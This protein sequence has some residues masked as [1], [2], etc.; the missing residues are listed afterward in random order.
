MHEICFYVTKK[1]WGVAI[2]EYLT[3]E[4]TNNFL[5][6]KQYGKY[7]LSLRSFD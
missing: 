2:F 6:H 5:L 4:N 7:E 1:H 3:Y